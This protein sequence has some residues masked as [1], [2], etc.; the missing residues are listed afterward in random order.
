MIGDTSFDI[1]VGK[2]AKTNTIAVTYGYEP[3]IEKTS[4][5]A[6]HYIDSL[7]ELLDTPP[8]EKTK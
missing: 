7:A 8:K 1:E 3:D 6:D 5:Y 4:P 2:N